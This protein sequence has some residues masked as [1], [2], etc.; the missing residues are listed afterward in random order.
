MR[1]LVLILALMMS[2]C[3]PAVFNTEVTEF[4]TAVDQTVDVVAQYSVAEKD[5]R[6]AGL[7]AEISR[8]EQLVRFSLE[9]H[10]EKKDH[11]TRVQFD[12]QDCQLTRQS[13]DSN[14]VVDQ[15]IEIPVIER[16]DVSKLVSAIASYAKGLNDITRTTDS[17]SILE[18]LDSLRTGI[19]DLAHEV[20]EPVPESALRFP[21]VLVVLF[22]KILQLHFSQL[23]YDYLSEAVKIADP[24]IT[25]NLS[26]RASQLDQLHN[27]ATRLR[28]DQ[29]ELLLNGLNEEPIEYRRVELLTRVL[30]EKAALDK[31]LRGDPP[32]LLI[33]GLIEAH[34]RLAKSID[35]P[36][37][38]DPGSDI[39][40]KI[41]SFQAIRNFANE[42]REIQSALAAL[43]K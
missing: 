38:S 19:R 25:K 2:S 1:Q 29:L 10:L 33:N 14:Q 6:L 40:N 17:V 20:E 31:L 32:S 36:S 24:W 22:Q 42:V 26:A 35:D 3:A 4:R 37:S 7:A 12:S 15:R 16:G 41:A 5:G 43:N 28:F 39:S 13:I 9:C 23:R 30:N 21:N 27:R 8:K 34:N 18:N 11:P